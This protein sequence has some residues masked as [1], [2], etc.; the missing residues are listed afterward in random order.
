MAYSEKD[1]I[2]YDYQNKVNALLRDNLIVLPEK[3]VNI[4]S[5]QEFNDL[6]HQYKNNLIAVMYSS[7][8]CAA[9]HAF[10]PIFEQ[11]QKSY[12]AKG[13]IFATLNIEMNPSIAAQFQIMGTPTIGFIKNQKLL[14]REMGII[15]PGPFRQ[16]LDRL[17]GRDN[18][19]DSMYS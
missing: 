14:D 11:M 2:D 18:G 10:A 17:L 19:F 1:E 8:T 6:V 3:V 9:C 13:V 16:L 4:R 15:P 12:A 7:N 5:A